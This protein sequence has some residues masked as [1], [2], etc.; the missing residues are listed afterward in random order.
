MILTNT[1][2][3]NQYNYYFYWYNELTNDLL[4]DAL[5]NHKHG[6]HTISDG[7]VK[8]YRVGGNKYGKTYLDIPASFDIET[9]KFYVD[10]VP[11]STMYC[12]QFG[13]ND[14]VIMG[15]TWL[16][17]ISLLDRIK[18]LIKPEKS[19][20]LLVAVHN[21]TFEFSFMRDWLNITES[22]L[23][24]Q[25]NPLTIEH[26]NFII[27]FDTLA[28][29]QCKLKKL[30]ET[31]C[32]TRKC[33]GDLD[34]EK[35]RVSSNEYVTP[36]NDLELSYCHNDV[37][38]LCEYMRFYNDTYL[39]NKKRP[40]TATGILNDEIKE[41]FKAYC[42]T[43]KNHKLKVQLSQ[44]K[45]DEYETLMF[46]CYRGGYVHGNMYYIDEELNDIDI[47]GVDFTSSYPACML[48]SRYGLKWRKAYNIR[49]IEDIHDL[50]NNGRA[51]IFMIE[52]YNVK[53]RGA[54]SIE[55]ASKCIELD[56]AVLDNGRV[57]KCDKMLVYLTMLDLFNYERFYTFSNYK[58]YNVSIAK[59]EYLPEYLI[60]PML[61][62]Y[63]LKNELKH[64]GLD[65]TQEYKTAK[66]RVNSFYGLTV[67]RVPLKRVIYAGG[68]WLETDATPYEKQVEKKALTPHIGVFISSWARYNLLQTVAE[69]EENGVN[70]YYMDTDSIKCDDNETSRA[71]INAYN[72]HIKTLT[73]DAI[74]RTGCNEFV[75]GLGE[76]D[77]EFGAGSKHGK[78]TNCK[79]LGAKRYILTTETGYNLQTIAGL[80][81]QWIFE[82]VKNPISEYYNKNPFDIFTDD[83]RAID[84]KLTT[85][86]IDEPFNFNVTDYLGHTTEINELSCV[87]L[88]NTDFNMS[89]N[90]LWAQLIV[91]EKERDKMFL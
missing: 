69:L 60:N 88:V 11:Y 23:K 55:S 7:A 66:S 73:D 80:P 81:K 59:M 15:R 54:H 37:L 43:H 51:S 36:L 62:Y 20:R 41:Q 64:K 26:D 50:Y 18:E 47:M 40:L 5:I 28:L 39:A 12:W 27:F 72:E 89:L 46:W 86:Y 24:E 91:E 53:N 3:I 8:K 1:N 35:I 16:E 30:A 82:Q 2:A 65:D 75:R 63:T 45:K 71:I 58:I 44:P 19:H 90:P 22:F 25:R 79:I 56:G 76:F 70:C 78:I 42:E 21:L 9:S 74:K 32:N 34:Y 84:C 48:F 49:T 10:G 67:K 85:K 4:Y 83:M 57:M 68:K 33:V 17:L 14:V 31:Y 29:T 61:N 38:I 87:S 52:L 13:I 77:I 6:R